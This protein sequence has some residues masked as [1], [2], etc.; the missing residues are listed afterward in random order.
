MC[1]ALAIP[2]YP[3]K[4]LTPL[5]GEISIVSKNFLPFTVFGNSVVIA[6]AT[7]IYLL[8]YNIIWHKKTRT[9]LFEENHRNESLWRKILVLITGYKVSIK[10]LKEKWH[11]Y[12]LEDVIEKE[13][14]KVQRKLI[15]LPSDKEREVIVER[16]GNAIEDNKIQDRVWASPGL[17]M[18]I[19]ITA[20]L[21]T[22]LLLGDFVWIF[23][24]FL[25]G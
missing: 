24:S 25:F 3:E 17:P 16:L 7:A 19:F 1:L 8:T 10:K 18:L 22:T 4:L 15:L 2:F 21:I 14:N 23:V 13:E 6:A 5:C 20:G 11:Y 12:P 9:T